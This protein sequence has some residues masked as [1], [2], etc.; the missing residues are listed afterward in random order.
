MIRL[1][2]S[3]SK[4]VRKVLESESIVDEIE[5]YVKDFC[6]HTVIGVND[7]IGRYGYITDLLAQELKSYMENKHGVYATIKTVHGE[8]RHTPK[9]NSIYWTTL[10]KWIYMEYGNC[11]I[12]IDPTSKQFRSLYPDIPDYYVSTNPPKWYYGNYQNIGY[13]N[14]GSKLNRKY[15]IK[16]VMREQTTKLGLV[17][18]FQYKVWGSISDIIHK[19]FYKRGT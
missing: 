5:S 6:K 8:L 13:G 3:P 7:I 9:I 4:E 14:L 17:E 16:T 2:C 10:H 12:Y 11:H 1:S 19:M 15:R 18:F